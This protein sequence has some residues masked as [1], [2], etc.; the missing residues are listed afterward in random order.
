MSQQV[1]DSAD[2][3]SIAVEK[4]ANGNIRFRREGET[5]ELW[6]NVTEREKLFEMI[7]QAGA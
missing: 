4:L 6:S 2:L 1:I 5:V 7:K 3:G